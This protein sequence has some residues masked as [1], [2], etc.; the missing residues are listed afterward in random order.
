MESMTV[1]SQQKLSIEEKKQN[2]YVQ[3]FNEMPYHIA[4]L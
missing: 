4:L 1:T 3:N 2:M